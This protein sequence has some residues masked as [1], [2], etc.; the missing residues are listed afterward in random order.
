MIKRASII[1]LFSFGL[2]FTVSA[3]STFHTVFLNG[4]DQAS[5]KVEQ[6]AGA[7]SQDQYTWRPAEGIRSV[8]EAMMHVAGA[9]FFF[10]N[11]LGAETPDGVNPR[12]LEAKVTT[13][14]EASKILKMSIEHVRKAIEKTSAESL[15]EEIDLFGNKTARMAVVL[16][17]GEHLNEH[18][19]QLI[20]YARSTGVVP[21]WSK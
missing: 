12:E 17:V 20:A 7:F 11:M 2:V 18:L 1:A 4:Y 8:S 10:A 16:L 15:E 9:N 5:D 19:G 3:Q 14:E 21:P 13:K 6:L